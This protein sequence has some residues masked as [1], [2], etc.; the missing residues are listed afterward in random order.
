[1]KNKHGQVY[2]PDQLSVKIAALNIHLK[3]KQY[4]LSI[5][6]KD[7]E[8]HSSKQVLEGKAKLLQQA[9]RSK[10]PNKARNLTK[11][12]EEVL[13]EESKLGGTT[14]E[15]LIN[16]MWWILTQHFG[17][18]C[19]QENNSMKV[20]DFQICKDDNVEFV[21]LLE[22]RLKPEKKTCTQSIAIFHFQPRKLAVGGKG[23]Q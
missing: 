12:K 23:A 5:I 6:V 9:G 20:D 18:P 15:A 17:L 8:F 4:P 21:Q 22:G 2:E 14:P 16:A 10:R 1:M 7:R 13:R 3:E 19:W 11:E